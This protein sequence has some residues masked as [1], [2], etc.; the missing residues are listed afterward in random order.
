MANISDWI[1]KCE[2]CGKDYDIPEEIP[3]NFDEINNREQLILK[4]PSKCPFCHTINSN[5]PR[6]K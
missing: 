6:W 1:I 4:A 3:S 5:I 2:N